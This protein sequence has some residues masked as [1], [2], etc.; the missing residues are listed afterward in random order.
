MGFRKIVPKE[1]DLSSEFVKKTFTVVVILL[2]T[3]C[4][5]SVKETKSAKLDS[6]VGHKKAL[7]QSNEKTKAHAAIP[8]ETFALMDGTGANALYHASELRLSVERMNIT[9]KA[10]LLKK[11]SYIE[12]KIKESMTGKVTVP[13]MY[14]PL[15]ERR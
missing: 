6:D 4:S 8:K 3:A 2:L 7:E 15:E 5:S 10:V 1:I 11:V 13:G 9:D 14:K 12:A